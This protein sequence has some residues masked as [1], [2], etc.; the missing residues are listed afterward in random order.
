MSILIAGMLVFEMLMRG[1]WPLLMAVTALFLTAALGFGLFISTIANSQQF[2]FQVA[3]ITSFLPTIVLSGFIFPIANMP[4]FLQY[5]TY[6][7]PARYYLSAVLKGVGMTEIWLHVGALFVF[8]AAV[9]G[10]ASVRLARER[11]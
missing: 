6:I 9:L 7:V 1:S 8:S 5:V 4:V 2:A 10:L 3:L 11:E